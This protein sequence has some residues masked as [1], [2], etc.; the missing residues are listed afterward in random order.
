MANTVIWSDET[1]RQPST[2]GTI[3]TSRVSPISVTSVVSSSR[4]HGD[5]RLL[6]RVHS[7]VPGMS[8]SLPTLTRP[9]SAG[10]LAVDRHGVLEVAEQNVHR[11]RDVRDLGD[12]LL[13]GEVQEVDHPR[14]LERDLEDRVGGADGQRLSEIAGVSFE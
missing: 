1:Y 10:L 5:S 3:T 8:N 7:A 6:T 2:L 12:H 4:I 9:S 11:G 13:V 14:R